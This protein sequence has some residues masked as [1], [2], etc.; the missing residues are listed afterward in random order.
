MTSAVNADASL[1]QGLQVGR[2]LVSTKTLG[3]SKVVISPC[4]PLTTKPIFTIQLVQLRFGGLY[5]PSGF[6]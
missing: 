5:E 2:Q 6:S 4:Y 1:V 3:N